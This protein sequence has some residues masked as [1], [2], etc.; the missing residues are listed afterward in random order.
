MTRKG[1]VARLPVAVREQLNE[2]LRT[3]EEGKILVAWLNTLPEVKDRMAELFGG[4]PMREQNLSQWKKGGYR[5]WL[6]Q[7]EV[8][9]VAK[10]LERRKL[11]E[12]GY[13]KMLRGLSARIALLYQAMAK[14][15]LRRSTDEADFR[16]LRQFMADL[17]ALRR[18]DGAEKRLRTE[19]M[20]LEIERERLAEDERSHQ[21]P[22]QIF[23]EPEE[24]QTRG[25]ASPRPGAAGARR[26]SRSPIGGSWEPLCRPARANQTKS[27]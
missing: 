19:R 22:P 13:R 1:K 9:E 12:E 15:L 18:T 27:G 20:R 24:K 6:D 3:G 17:D 25:S 21:I 11:D 2:R 23:S 4:F 5:D 7:R 26:S 10:L 8:C 16:L 14:R